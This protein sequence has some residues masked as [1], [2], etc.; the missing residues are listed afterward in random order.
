[1]STDLLKQI[2]GKSRKMLLVINVI[3]WGG[4][5]LFIAAMGLLIWA[6]FSPAEAF[7]AEKGVAHWSVSASIFGQGM[8]RAIIPFSILQPLTIDMFQVKAA[9]ITF[10]LFR[11]L[12]F[13]PLFLYGVVQ[14]QKIFYSIRETNTPFSAEIASRLRNIS[15]VIILYALIADLFINI[16]ITTFVT[17]ILYI[18]LLNVSISG[19]T[20]G[21][22]VLIISHIFRYG[23]YLQDEF[24]TTL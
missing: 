4:V 21:V 19:L 8:F 1:M 20:V 23:S 11:T 18:D 22:L 9:F 12:T 16:A 14:L 10:F 5:V 2:R 15:Y 3:K 7:V 13:F 17:N 6:S 24:D